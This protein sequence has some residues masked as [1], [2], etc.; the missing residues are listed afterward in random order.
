MEP[1]NA[2]VGRL[3]TELKQW[4]AKLDALVASAAKAGAETKVSYRT[5]IDELKVKYQTAHSKLDDLRYVRA[6]N[7][8][9]VKAGV[10]KA[11]M[12][13]EVAFKKLKN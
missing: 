4:G 12:E 3:E 10:E 8:S 13:L 9:I 1:L 7:W 11:W 6:E 5:R 2:Q